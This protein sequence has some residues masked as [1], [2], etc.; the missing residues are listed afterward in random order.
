MGVYFLCVIVLQYALE[1]DMSVSWCGTY[2]G[3]EIFVDKKFSWAN[4][5]KEFNWHHN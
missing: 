3:L 2:V 1:Y 5:I 4:S